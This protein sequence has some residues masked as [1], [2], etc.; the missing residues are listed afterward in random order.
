VKVL[1]ARAHL[2]KIFENNILPGDEKIRIRVATK[3]V[4]RT[5]G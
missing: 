4:L 5:M 3:P 1:C 2:L